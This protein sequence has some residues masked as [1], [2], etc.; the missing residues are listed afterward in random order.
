MKGLQ[1]RCIAIFVIM[2]GFGPKAVTQSLLVD[3]TATPAVKNALAFYNSTFA[4]Q[5]HLYNGKEYKDYTHKFDSGLPYFIQSEW[6]NGTVDYDG[7]IYQDVP[8]LYDVVAQQVI[9][10]NY[11][12]ASKIELLKEK[13]KAFSLSGHSFLNIP[14][15][16][17]VS[18]NLDGGFYDVLLNG[19]MVL[20]ARRTKN[21][22]AVLRQAVEYRVYDKDHYYIKRDNKYFTVDSKKSFLEQFGNKRK[23]IQQYMK[24]NKLRFRKDPEQVMIK[25]VG[26]YNQTT[27]Q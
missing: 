7:N 27:H 24:Q 21:I 3:S 1:I 8:I 13:I 26:F 6:S 23:E 2:V 12:S 5:L 14:R 11:N 17:L 19:K 18:A 15:D 16:S 25:A 22:Q 10:L 20:L 9:I 4:D